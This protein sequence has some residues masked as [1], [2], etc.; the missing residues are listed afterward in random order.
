MSKTDSDSA[1]FPRPNSKRVKDFVPT[2]SAEAAEFF[3]KDPVAGAA[4]VTRGELMCFN[5]SLL[6]QIGSLQQENETLIQE[7]KDTHTASRTLFKGQ[8]KEI[9]ELYESFASERLVFEEAINE[10]SDARE[11]WE[12]ACKAMEEDLESLVS[13]VGAL[14]SSEKGWIGR[15]LKFQYLFEQMDRIGLQQSEDIFDCFRDIEVPEVSVALK[16][17][18]V[19]TTATDN[20]DFVDEVSDDE[21][22]DEDLDEDEGE[23]LVEMMAVLVQ[24]ERLGEEELVEDDLMETITFQGVLYYR[25]RRS[26]LVYDSDGH[27]VGIFDSLR[28]MQWSSQITLAESQRPNGLSDLDDSIGQDMSDLFSEGDED[29]D[30]DND[31]DECLLARDGW[32][33]RARHWIALE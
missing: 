28:G 16:D 7:L 13:E 23:D 14:Q 20:I 25:V 8:A 1:V 2:L 30:S 29:T 9:D 17:E 11:S 4:E 6:D 5:Q 10:E 21:D 18:F 31:D 26:G 24:V 22:L 12:E 19:T 32:I 33:R 3:P 15:T 27:F